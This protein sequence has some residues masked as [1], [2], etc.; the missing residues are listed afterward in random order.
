[1]VAFART[2]TGQKAVTDVMKVIGLN[3]PTS[4]ADSTDRTAQQFWVLATEVGQQLLDEFTW[5]ALVREFTIT[6]TA[7]TEY[8]LPDDFNSFYNDANW[9]RTNRQPLIGSLSED[10]WQMLKATNLGG[11][12]IAMQY[13]IANDNVVFNYVGDVGQTIVIPYNSRAWC[14]AA[15]GVTYQDN[16]IL[17]DDVV[18]YDPQLFK[19]AL[20]VAWEVSKKFDTSASLAE[21]NRVLA[22]AKAKDSPARTLSLAGNR[23]FPYL[24]Y[25]NIPETNYGL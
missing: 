11:T 17:N 21:Y 7:A 3:A 8:P 1:M 15:D 16:L 9:N 25:R 18:L 2:I 19:A 14:V 20:K 4:I 10:E 13:Q 5:Q 22:A 23:G 12:S 6:T 24:G